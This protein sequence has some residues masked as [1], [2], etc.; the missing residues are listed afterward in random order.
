MALVHVD[1]LEDYARHLEGNADE[2]RAL[3]QD[4]LITVTSFFRDPDAFQA[5]C[6]KV[7]PALL[8]N[9]PPGSAH[10]RVGAR[11]R[12]RRGGLFDRHLPAGA[13]GRAEGEPSFQVFGT[14]LSREAFEKARAGTYLANIA[15]DVSPE[16]L[17]RF[18]TKVDARY[19]VTKAVRD[20]CVFARHDLTRDPRSAAWT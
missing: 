8:K 14:D 1:T 13:R 17:R 15:Q 9:R 3:Y 18:F 11:L 19:Q 4:C 10:P 16:R 7:F 5:L 20:M 12:H 2:V 6:E